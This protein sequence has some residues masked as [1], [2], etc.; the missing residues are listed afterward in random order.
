[1]WRSATLILEDDRTE[2]QPGAAPDSPPKPQEVKAFLDEY[3]D[4]QD[5]TQEETGCAVYNH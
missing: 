5:Q 3:C 1:V 2:A 4:R